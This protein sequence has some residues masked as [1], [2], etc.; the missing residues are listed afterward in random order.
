ME[1]TKIDTYDA[2]D[3]FK[4]FE[5]IA[6]AMLDAWA[7]VDA[8]GRVVKSNA[9]FQQVTGMKGKAIIK[10]D[11][12]DSCLKFEMDGEPY[13]IKDLLKTTTPTRLDEVGGSSEAFEELILLVGYYPF[14]GDTDQP[15]GAFILI[16]DVT[17]EAGLQGK[18]KQKS[19]LSITDKLTGLYNR[20]HFDTV[21][22]K[23][24][25]MAKDAEEGS[26][27]SHLTVIMFDIDKF[28]SV[29]DTYG[30]QAGDLIIAKVASIMAENFRKSDIV[31]RYGGEEFLVILPSCDAETAAKS[32][33]KV[34]DMIQKGT[35]VW[36]GTEIPNSISAGVAQVNLTTEDGEATIARADLGLYEAKETGRNRVIIH[37]PE[38]MTTFTKE[39]DILVNVMET[40]G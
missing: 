8:N 40:R 27:D 15:Y 3:T 30:H 25:Q 9:L 21:M 1:A 23:L 11:S 32:A 16:R 5:G 2:K 29:N 4:Q 38:G 13:S 31:C 12:F 10:A 19:K 34:R 28:K 14:M 18:Y 36:D 22:P 39:E 17:A 6:K 20:A 37:R 35:Y 33:E 26:A 7:V 24:I